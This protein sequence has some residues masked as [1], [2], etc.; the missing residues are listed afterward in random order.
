MKEQLNPIYVIGHR[1][2]D[3]D[4]I[5][6]AIGYAHLKRE[7]GENAKPA[8]AGKLNAETKFVLENFGFEA[9]E[10]IQD[11]RKIMN[12]FNTEIGIPNTNVEKKERMVSDEVNSN[13]IETQIKMDEILDRLK[14]QCKE[15]NTMAG[16]QI[17]SVDWRYKENELSQNLN[18]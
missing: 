6:S 7:M 13:N 12:S 17:I 3:T 8:R 11:I 9:P 14:G 1:N 15:L 4:S 2:P 16:V 10:L 18:A 5:C